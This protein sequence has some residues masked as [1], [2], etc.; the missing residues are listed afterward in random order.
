M[1]WKVINQM[2]LKIQLVDSWN[3]GCFSVTDLTKMH[4]ISRP[5]VYKWLGR[6]DRLGI[7]GLKELTRAPKNCPHR[8]SKKILDLVIQEKLRNRKRGPRKVRVQLKRQYP[9]LKLPAIS[10]I[11]Y[12]L[13]KEG[14]VEKRKKRLR[15]PAYSEPFKECDAPNKVWSMDYKGQF[16]TTNHRVCYPFT[17]SDNFSRFLLRCT[18]LPGPRRIATKEALI[19]AFREYGLPDAIRSDNGTPFAGKCAGGLSRLSIWFIQLGITPERIEKGCPQDNGRHERMHRTLKNDALDP[20]A[21][22]LTQQQKVFDSFRYDYNHIRPHESLGDE[23]PGKHYKRS[24]RP[25]IED[26]H[27]PSYDHSCVVRRVRVGG[28]IKFMGKLFYL[29]KL[30]AGQP[31]GLKEIADGLW[32]IRYS[33]YTLASI[34]LKKNRLITN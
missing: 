5:T 24:N 9:D 13:K 23:T 28:R 16:F 21:K 34:D 31:I 2:D 4:G 14:L 32:Q 15:V 10:T 1:P 3:K 25:Y 12:W 17:L 11:S 20:P 29:T 19:S 22:N 30:L 8:T 7:E 6:Y 26:P 27:E 18:A 33:F